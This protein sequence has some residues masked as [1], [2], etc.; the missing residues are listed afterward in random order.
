MVKQASGVL[1]R[2]MADL[3]SDWDAAMRRGEYGRAWDVSDAVRANNDPA[4]R[5]DPALPYHL[6]WVW[7]GRPF[8]GRHVLVRC[9]H[10]LGDTLQFL[11]YLPPL[12]QRAA[13]VTLEVQPELLPLARSVSGIDRLVGFDPAH[14]L[15]PAECDIEIMELAAALRI[16]PA[17]L[18]PPY[19]CAAAGPAAPE[20]LFGLC[21]QAGG[22]DGARSVPAELFAP[23][24]QR[25]CVTLCPGPTRLPVANP[26]GCPAT[27]GETAGL[28]ASLR[29]VITV[30]TMVAHLAGALNVP[31]WLLLKHTADWRWMA[32]R[33]DSPWY[34]SM[35]LYRQPAPGDW[36]SV[37]ADVAR[38][39]AGS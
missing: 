8:D 28:V 18:P 9:Y 22:W 24:T 36:G 25:R 29:L 38:D 16:K 34:P 4:H 19:L 17:V 31:T 5:D 3:G 10:G 20:P 35:R 7:D 1:S 15:P 27:V 33:A 2:A 37:L 14:P 6:R 32:D 13:S 12:R 26:A 39:L 21:W 11:R 23:L 30:D